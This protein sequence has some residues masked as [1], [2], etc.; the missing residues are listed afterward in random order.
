MVVVFMMD[1][2]LAQFFAVEFP[3]AVGA[4]PWKEFEC[5]LAKGLFPLRTV[6]RCH[7]SLEINSDL[8]RLYFTAGRERNLDSVVLGSA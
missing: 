5:L 6:A 3:P 2:E 8:I 1:G 7:A 4:D